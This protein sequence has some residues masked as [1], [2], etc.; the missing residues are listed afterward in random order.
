MVNTLDA[1]HTLGSAMRTIS[2]KWGWFV[3]IGVVDLALGGIVSTNLVLANLA[4]VLFLGGIVL[5]SGVLHVIHSF[6]VR[7]PCNF[8]F[9]FVGGVIYAAAGAIIIY[10]PVLASVELSLVAGVFFVVAGGLR[11]SGGFRLRPAAGWPWLTA[12]G[13]LTV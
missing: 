7:G 2:L 3:A 8:L 11:L 6:F 9:W 4:S 10:D 1:R 5:A 12:A 13:A